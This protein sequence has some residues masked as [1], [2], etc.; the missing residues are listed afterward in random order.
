[1]SL[2]PHEPTIGDNLPPE[3]YDPIVERLNQ[4]PEYQALCDRAAELLAGVERVPEVIKDDYTGDRVGD[5]ISK[6]IRPM[7]KSFRKN[8]AKRDH[9]GYWRTLYPDM[10]EELHPDILPIMK[11][12]GYE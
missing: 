8:V 5:F 11:S 6:Q 1:M 9:I 4:T 2:T 12:L 7:I 10:E 3:D